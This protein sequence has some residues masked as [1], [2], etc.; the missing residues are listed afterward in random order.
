[1]GTTVHFDRQAV[2]FVY[3]HNEGWDTDLPKRIKMATKV[4]RHQCTD[5]VENWQLIRADETGLSHGLT[6]VYEVLRICLPNELIYGN[7]KNIPT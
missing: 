1:M 2:A 7:W 5:K 3:I 6:L 4:K